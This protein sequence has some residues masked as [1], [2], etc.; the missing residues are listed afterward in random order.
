MAKRTLRV[1]VTCQ[2]I[3]PLIFSGDPALVPKYV[4]ESDY[5]PMPFYGGKKTPI[6]FEEARAKAEHYQYEDGDYFIPGD[7]LWAALEGAGRLVRF[8]EKQ[9]ITVRRT[10]LLRGLIKIE[11][12]DCVIAVPDKKRPWVTDLASRRSPNHPQPI[13]IARPRFDRW[14]FTAYISIRTNKIEEMRIRE[15]FDKAGKNY[16]LLHNRPAT[17][18][19]NG[20]FIV[21]R[22][23]HL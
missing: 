18:G 22:W 19:T 17:K 11:N 8:D 5:F 7:A 6:P 3:T 13:Q 10:T 15:L 23:L 1:A 9:Q 16:G 2:G 14:E 21:K 20:Q 12:E 4:D